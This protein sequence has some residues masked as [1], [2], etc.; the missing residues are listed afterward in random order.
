MRDQ[1]QAELQERMAASDE[2]TSLDAD[3]DL[4]HPNRFVWCPGSC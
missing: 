3:A 2:G 1:G 4:Y